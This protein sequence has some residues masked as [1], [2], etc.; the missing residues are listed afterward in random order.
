MICL[1]IESAFSDESAYFDCVIVLLALII[2]DNQI[3]SMKYF[4]VMK[5]SLQNEF[6]WNKSIHLSENY[7]IY[8]QNICFDIVLCVFLAVLNMQYLHYIMNSEILCIDFCC[9]YFLI[10]LT[11]CIF[12]HMF[13]HYHEMS[14]NHVSFWF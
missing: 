8:N 11:D 4:Y 13:N 1:C 5:Y 7:Y 3:I 6:F 12:N 10:W 14:F 9:N 2:T